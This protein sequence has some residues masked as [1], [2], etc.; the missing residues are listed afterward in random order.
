MLK[1]PKASKGLF[2][3]ISDNR[4]LLLMLAPATLLVFVF[5]YIPMGG[6]VLAFK[7]FRYQAGIFGSPWVGFENFRFFFISGQAFLVTRNTLL[8]NLGFIVINTCLEIAF[9][10]ILSE[11]QGKRL[12]RVVQSFMFLPFFISW[13][14]VSS[15]AYNILNFEYGALNGLLKS[16]G[17]RPVDA[18]STPSAWKYILVGLKAWKEVGY[19]TV[20]YLAAIVAIDSEMY[21]AAEID[22]ANIFQRIRSVTIPCIVPTMVILFL[23]AV[24]GIFRG[25]FGLFYQMIGN[26][27]LLYDATDIIDTFVYRSLTQSSEIGMAAAAGLYQ[28][29]MCFVTIMIVNYIVKRTQPD[30]SLF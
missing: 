28:S 11:M 15:I 10:V 30:Y 14:V 29:I 18:Y 5:S 26:N 6:I 22:G 12:K 21:D 1:E 24:G 16:L 3:S 20:V 7:H 2:A 13:V 9:A 25:D 23:L 17:L 19:G 27:G 4:T 8:Y